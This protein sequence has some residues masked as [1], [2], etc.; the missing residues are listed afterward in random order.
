MEILAVLQDGV[1]H[2]KLLTYT[3]LKLLQTKQTIAVPQGLNQIWGLS[4]K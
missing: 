2:S 1:F 3:K 4:N